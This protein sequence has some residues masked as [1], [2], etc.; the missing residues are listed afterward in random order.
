MTND[1]LFWKNSNSFFFA[2]KKE[3]EFFQK[4][5]RKIK[6]EIKKIM[7]T[8]YFCLFRKKSIRIVGTT[9]IRIFKNELMNSRMFSTSWG[10]E[11]ISIIY[12]QG[13]HY[14][15]FF[16]L[17]SWLLY[18]SKLGEFAQRCDKWRTFWKNSNSFFLCKEKE[19]EFFKNYLEK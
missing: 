9:T 8:L 16:K 11:R 14:Y 4:L 19:F 15:S 12:S 2:K 3:F 10:L 13:L 5:F 18:F 1:E 6:I 17:P 7:A